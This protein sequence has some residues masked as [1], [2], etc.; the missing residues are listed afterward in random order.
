M[1]DSYKSQSKSNENALH[2]E[3]SSKLQ[4]MVNDP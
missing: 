4:E 2:M 1:N 3:K